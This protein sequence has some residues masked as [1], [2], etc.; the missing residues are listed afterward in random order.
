MATTYNRSIASFATRAT[1]SGTREP[2]EEGIHSSNGP[3]KNR[4]PMNSYPA[5]GPALQGPPLFH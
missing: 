3:W 4:F 1:K 2:I 5:A